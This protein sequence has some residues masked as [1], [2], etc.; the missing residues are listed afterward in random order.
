[1]RRGITA[2]RFARLASRAAASNPRLHLATD[3][4]AGFPGETEAEFGETVRLVRELPFASLH[5]FPFSPR[6]G[7]R[8][9]ALFAEHPI[10]PAV[11]T[12]RAAAL[13]ALAEEKARAFRLAAAGTTADAVVL[14]GGIA[15]TDHY[16]EASLEEPFPPGTRRRMRLRSEGPGAALVAASFGEAGSISAP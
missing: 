8:G 13:R 2:S 14:R 1:M 11:V 16:L 5:V 12:R 10:P 6:S 3:L 15:L 9:E 7:T 4:I